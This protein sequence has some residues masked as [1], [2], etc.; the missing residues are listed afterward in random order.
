MRIKPCSPARKSSPN[1]PWMHITF[2]P[3]DPTRPREQESGIYSC[4]QSWM[5]LK[6]K[7]LKTTGGFTLVG[8]LG[9]CRMGVVYLASRRTELALPDRKP[10]TNALE[11]KTQRPRVKNLL[12]LS[13][14]GRYRSNWLHIVSLE[15]EAL[16]PDFRQ[17]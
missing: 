10:A 9:Q 6:S 12:C 3:N 8:H 7:G 5:Q 13:L 15:R 1:V 17:N 4:V 16:S 2:P 11:T 14:D